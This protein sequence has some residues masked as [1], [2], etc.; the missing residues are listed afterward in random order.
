MPGQAQI[1]S[2]EAIEAF[3]A[4]LVVYLAQMRPV[5][6]EISSEVLHTRA[7]LEDD[8]ARYW[9]QELRLRS[10]K[11][12]DAKQE[13]FT[14]SL[15]RMGDASS[16]Q[17]MA[18]QRAQREM[19]AVEDKL[20]VLKKWNRELENRTSP[21]VKQMEQLHGFLTVEMDHAVAYL[22]QAL[23]ALAAY[24]DVMPAAKSPPPP[25][26]GAGGGAP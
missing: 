21:L 24:R 14:A 23:A 6:E 20:V 15:S 16:F 8:R 12:E 22:D 9:K 17:Q 19:R 3:R 26:A 10:R 5:L 7:W 13:L 18:V 4:Q 2:V 25:A 1:T 11:L